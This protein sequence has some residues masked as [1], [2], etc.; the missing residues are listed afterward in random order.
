VNTEENIE[1]II[2]NI[3]ATLKFEGLKPSEKSIA[4]SRKILQREMTVKT[5]R[6]EI[7]AKINK[8]KNEMSD[9]DENDTGTQSIYCYSESQVYKNKFDIRNGDL[10]D[11]LEADLTTLR[12]VAL[13]INPKDIV[14]SIKSLKNMHCDIFKDLYFFAG[15]IR[16]EEISKGNTLFC[17]SEFIESSLERL[18]K[19]VKTQGFFKKKSEDA[20]IEG[21]VFLMG[22]LNIIHPFREGNGRCIRAFVN[23][24]ALNNGYFIDWS[25]T[26]ADD[27]LKAVIHTVNFE[28]SPL[29]SIIKAI[30][31]K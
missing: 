22:E 4:C 16:R 11:Q 27:I 5:A 6:D 14:F 21:I 19:D 10:L 12:L 20:F 2:N 25:K 28:Y 29:K 9:N 31:V 26:N 30:M 24:I 23:N 8:N 18:F 7:I 1:R 13:F 15:K 3:L 17:K